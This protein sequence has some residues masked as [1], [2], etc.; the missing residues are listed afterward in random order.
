ME[1]P[2]QKYF[3]FK[4][5]KNNDI[6]IFKKFYI[7]VSSM[8]T[9]E[10]SIFLKPSQQ[11]KQLRVNQPEI[12]YT[13]KK[14][15]EYLYYFLSPLIKDS[16]SHFQINI[17]NV[18][19]FE[20][21]FHLYFNSIHQLYLKKD[22]PFLPMDLDN[23]VE[24]KNNRTTMTKIYPQIKAGY[25]LIEIEPTRVKSPIKIEAVINNQKS[26]EVNSVYQEELNIKS[27]LQDFHVFI[28]REG[29]LTLIIESL[30][31]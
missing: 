8:E 17:Y 18:N 12:V 21:Q 9:S 31:F 1:K 5:R 3:K 30:N 28:P 14:S 7:R 15:K 6:F 24:V 29:E 4:L 23:L 20:Q 16:V 11:F 10:F 19:H 22:S 26:L 27:R 2:E 25:F 13:N